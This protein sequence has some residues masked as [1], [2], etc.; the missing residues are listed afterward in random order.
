MLF[1]HLGRKVAPENL[2]ENTGKLW[3]Q[4]MYL[5]ICIIGLILFL[6]ISREE[7]YIASQAPVIFI[8]PLVLVIAHTCL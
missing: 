5:R 4:T 7:R 1:C 2:L 8:F 6:D 3:N